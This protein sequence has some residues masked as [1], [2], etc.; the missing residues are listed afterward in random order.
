VSG[1][2]YRRKP[3]YAGPGAPDALARAQFWS[4]E[5]GMALAELVGEDG[6]VAATV[7]MQAGYGF[8]DVSISL[9]ISDEKPVPVGATAPPK[10]AQEALADPHAALRAVYVPAGN[11]T[12]RITRGSVKAETSLRIR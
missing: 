9:R 11:Y 5:A 7:Q 3:E 2:P 1:L 4:N 12:L 8:N 10:T 6:R